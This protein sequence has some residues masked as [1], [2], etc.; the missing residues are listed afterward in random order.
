M[1]KTCKLNR[2]LIKSVLVL[3]LRSFSF[4]LS[5]FFCWKFFS[6]SIH[7]FLLLSLS[8]TCFHRRRLSFFY[9]FSSMNAREHTN[10]EE[11]KK[12]LP[13]WNVSKKYIINFISYAFCTKSVTQRWLNAEN[14]CKITWLVW[15]LWLLS[16]E[17]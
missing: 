15:A 6:N 14:S 3:G 10:Q 16:D 4:I 1:N 5:V 9:S 13:R 17:N 8:L 12:K 11:N 7:P 2:Q